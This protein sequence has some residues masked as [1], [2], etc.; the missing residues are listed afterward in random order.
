M[1]KESKAMFNYLSKS[2]MQ[3]IFSGVC[4]GLGVLVS[5]IALTGNTSFGMGKLIASAAFSAGL[6]MSF[7]ANGKLYTGMC[8]FIT[9]DIDKGIHPITILLNLMLAW[10]SNFLGA[11][12]LVIFTFPVLDNVA[13]TFINIG[14]VKA[15]LSSGDMFV[16]AFLCN[17]LVCLAVIMARK[18]KSLIDLVVAIGIPVTVF[19]VCGFEHSVA[20]M[21]YLPMA[22]LCG[23]PITSIALL[24]SI[25]MVTFGNFIGGFYMSAYANSLG[26]FEEE[27]KG[28]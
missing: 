18:A 12:M 19:V 7:M 20:N 3:G 10:A 28:E 11:L 4:I 25:I 15:S 5:T 23:A 21:F 16:K 14:V 6:I 9:R 26:E 17:L 13:K 2:T 8:A 24:K 27:K 22:K 1:N